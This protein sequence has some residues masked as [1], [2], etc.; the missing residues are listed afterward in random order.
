ML[1]LVPM[2]LLRSGSLCAARATLD[3]GA[4]A[5]GAAASSGGCAVGLCGAGHA[6]RAPRRSAQGERG[7]GAQLERL[8]YC[9][10]ML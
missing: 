3:P 5:L 4:E 9:G 2:A 7:R 10:G 6:G 1:L 8:C